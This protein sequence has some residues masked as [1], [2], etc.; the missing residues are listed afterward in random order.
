VRLLLVRPPVVH[1][2]ADFYGSIPGIPSGLCY[3]A[4]AVR[5]QGVEVDLLDCYGEMPHRFYRFRGRWRA[6]GLRPA[7]AAGRVDPDLTAVGISVHCASE[8]SISIALVRETRRRHPHLPVIVGGYHATFL[9]EDFI[10]AG[11]DYVVM[12]EG[13]RRLPRLL[14][15]LEAGEDPSGQEGVAGRGF[16]NP[17]ESKYTVDLDSM[18]FAAVDLVDLQA[19]WKLGYGHGPV[20]G[21]YMNILTSRGCPF[22][23]AFCQAPQM[24]GRRWLAKSPERVLEE[25][26]HHIGTY[27]VTDFHIQ[28]ENFGVDRGRAEEVCR[29]LAGL[30]PPVTICFPSGVKMETLDDRM[31]ELLAAA[32]CRYLS[33]SPETGSRRVLGLMNK[34]ANIDLVPRLVRRARALGIRT[35]TFFVAGYPGETDTDR[36]ETRAY[37]RRLARTGADEMVMPVLTPFPATAAMDEPSLQGWTDVDELCFSPVWRE[38]YAELDRYRMGTY[39]HFYAAK[40]LHHPLALLRQLW[41]VITG[42]SETKGEM[43]ARRLPRD[44]LDSLLSRLR[45]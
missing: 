17:R 37:V 12:G 9:P 11:A 34:T 43:T 38:D 21:P 5:E 15:A 23:C 25:V 4:A 26:R 30:D 33:M 16:C 41:N 29:L 45:R 36:R 40:L 42:R 18:P 19:Y 28:D 8:H 39:L 35:C 6:R 20:R 44:L 14:R 22:D 1:L 31:L 7:E 32:G 2:R 10:G 13:E 24:C 27:G 3:L